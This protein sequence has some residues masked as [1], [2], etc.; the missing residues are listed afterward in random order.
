MISFLTNLK[1]T[2]GG[3]AAEDVVGGLEKAVNDFKFTNQG[4]NLVFLIADAPCHGKQYHD[5]DSDDNK[6]SVPEGTLEKV[7]KKY[8]EKVDKLNMY[9]FTLTT[10]TDKMYLIMKQNAKDLVIT[11]KLVPQQFFE[12]VIQSVMRTLVKHG[13]WVREVNEEEKQKVQEEQKY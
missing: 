12:T 2:G 10:Y 3:D 9:C 4:Q 13:E 1:A 8:W 7:V 11:D 5:I 6:D